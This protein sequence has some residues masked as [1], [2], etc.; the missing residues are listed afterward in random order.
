[1][2]VDEKVVLEILGE[3]DKITLKEL[4]RELNKRGLD[5]VSHNQLL[6]ALKKISSIELKKIENIWYVVKKS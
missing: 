3:R 4:K 6:K 1:M 2:V 5:W